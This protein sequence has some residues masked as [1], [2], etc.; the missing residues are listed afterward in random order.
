M[1]FCDYM[2][3]KKIFPITKLIFNEGAFSCP[4][5]MHSFHWGYYC[6]YMAD[7]VAK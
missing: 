7:P 1:N 5:K 3:Y 6:L 4:N 2:K